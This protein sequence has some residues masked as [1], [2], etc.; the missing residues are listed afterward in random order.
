[1]S[2]SFR[3]AA[4]ETGHASPMPVA[5]G[6]TGTAP[7]LDYHWH[8][9]TEP[10]TNPTLLDTLL[11]DAK[12]SNHAVVEASAGRLN[13]KNV[14]KA[15]TGSR[16]VTDRIARTLTDVVNELLMP[17]EKWTPRKLFPG[18]PRG[19]ATVSVLGKTASED[20]AHEE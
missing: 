2:R 11:T 4:I 18:F 3:G 5:A 9:M 19:K 16:P 20:E 12:L 6:M 8:H 7:R 14:Q 17:E 10:T 13:H 1:M 15:R